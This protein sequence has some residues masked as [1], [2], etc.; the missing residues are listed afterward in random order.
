M[1]AYRGNTVLKVQAIA[2]THTHVEAGGLSRDDELDYWDNEEK[3]GCSINLATQ[4][5]A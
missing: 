3:K 1:K 2:R 5:K 4:A